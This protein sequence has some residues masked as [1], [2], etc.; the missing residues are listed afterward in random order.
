M[1]TRAMAVAPVALLV[2]CSTSLL[3]QHTPAAPAPSGAPEFPVIMEHNVTAG[4]TPVGTKVRA[5]LTVATLVNGAVIPRNAVF[6]GEVIESV[7]K[8]ATDASRLAIRMDSVQWKKGTAPVKV[9]L[10]AWCYPSMSVPGGDLQYGPPQS[11]TRTWNGAGTYPDPNSPAYKP[12]PGADSDSRSDTVPDTAASVTSPH[13]VVMKNVESARNGDG[14]VTII[15][16][17]SNIKL[18]TLT[19]YVLATN[20]L[21][22]PK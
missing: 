17:H 18:D 16:S 20:D 14:A 11:P 10:T 19:T 21:L 13:R 22:P 4:N 7:A 9:Y 3:A 5:K 8:S 15:S 6:S 1:F 2:F 12:F